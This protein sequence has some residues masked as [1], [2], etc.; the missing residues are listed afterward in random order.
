MK[1]FSTRLP[2]DRACFSRYAR[3]AGLGNR[4]MRNHF[5]GFLPDNALILYEKALILRY[6]ARILSQPAGILS[7][8]TR[9]LT[10]P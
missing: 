10:Q 5:A 3:L 7:Q 4:F 2:G 8:P 1:V 6:H 9:I